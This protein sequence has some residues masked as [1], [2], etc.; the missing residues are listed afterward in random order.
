MFK[1]ESIDL[2]FLDLDHTLIF[3]SYKELPELNLM[4]KYGSW[5]WVYERPG[6]IDFARRVCQIAPTFVYTTAM[7]DY[8]TQAVSELAFKPQNIFTRENCLRV[9]D[10]YR[11]SAKHV[12]HKVTC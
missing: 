3:G 4:F 11:K 10:A 8:A 6:A 2:I 12:G 9:G 7:K 5:L 1:P